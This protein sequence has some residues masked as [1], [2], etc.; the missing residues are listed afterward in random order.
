[1]GTQSAV[2][3]VREVRARMPTLTLVRRSIIPVS[4]TDTTYSCR[5]VES[6]VKWRPVTAPVVTASA[7]RSIA[8]RKNLSRSAFS[9]GRD[10][11]GWSPMGFDMHGTGIGS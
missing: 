6:P 2:R 10:C 7:G 9:G 11:Q 4:L 5:A 8:A 3:E 1:M